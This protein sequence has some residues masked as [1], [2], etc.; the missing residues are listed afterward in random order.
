MCSFPGTGIVYVMQIMGALHVM[1]KSQ[2][3]AFRMQLAL[4]ILLRLCFST[5]LVYYWL[6]AIGTEAT[7]VYFPSFFFERAKH[8]FYSDHKSVYSIDPLLR[9]RRLRRSC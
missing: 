8:V 1:K 2:G 5:E 3:C 6:A 7:N 9:N 4:F